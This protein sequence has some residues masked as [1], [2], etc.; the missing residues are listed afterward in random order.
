MKEEFLHY[1]WKYRLLKTGNLKCCSGEKIEI[2]KPGTHNFDSGP[3]F[4]NAKIKI[5]DITW[6]GNVEIHV[7]SSDWY[8]HNHHT[9]KAFDNVILQAVYHHDKDVYRTN[10]QLIPTLVLD[11]DSRLLTNYENLLQNKLWIPCEKEIV[12]IDKFIISQWIEKLSIERLKEKSDS[13]NDLLKQNNNNWET[14]FY[15]QLASNFG[16]KLNSEPFELLAKSLPLNYLAK[17]K[18]NLLQIEALLFGQAGF[19]I[20]TGGDE[21]YNSLQKEYLFLKAK[22][23]LKPIEKHLWKFLR[24][25]PGNFPTIRIA[26]FAMLIYKSS[27]LFSKI[28][29]SVKPEEIKKLLLVETSEYWTNHYLFN[30]VSV[31]KVKSLGENSVDILII[32]TVIPFLFV[33]GKNKRDEKIATRAIGFLEKI[34]S[35]KN[36]ILQ[37]WEKLGIKSNSAQSSQALI[38]LKSKYCNIKNCLNCQIGN[39]VIKI[40]E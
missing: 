19:L 9:N 2:I 14:A 6:N 40:Q 36:S 34:K 24:S 28:I 17:H 35:E 11:F 37:S 10:G 33:Y 1:I 22:F 32:N 29:E 38:H 8:S 12:K 27:S 30:K 23:N 5:D 3:D 4:F 21:Y 13:V 26:Q 20:D 18:N 39:Q 25:R 7:N 16:F 15:T 31:N